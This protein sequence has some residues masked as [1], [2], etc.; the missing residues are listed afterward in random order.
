METPPEEFAS[1]MAVNVTG[2]YLMTKAFAPLIVAAKGRIINI[3]SI[4]GL[5]SS[6]N[7]GPY[8]MSKAAVENAR[9]L[10]RLSASARANLTSLEQ[11]IRSFRSRLN[12]VKPAG[13]TLAFPWLADQSDSTPLCEA[14]AKAGVLTAPGSAYGMPAHFRVGYGLAD[15]GDFNEAL[16]LMADV[17]GQ[18]H[19]PGKS[20]AEAGG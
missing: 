14:W 1:M 12:W 15:P 18:A 19:L 2:P 16:T 9:F 8:Q 13:G 17:L 20:T 3:G 6:A 10:D 5:L 11:F 4:S 7:L